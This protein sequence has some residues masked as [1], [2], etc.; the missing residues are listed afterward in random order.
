MY[1]HLWT[2]ESRAWV[3]ENYGNMLTRELA[4]R[5]SQQTGHRF[6][7]NMVVGLAWRH[8]LV[9]GKRPRKTDTTA[10]PDTGMLTDDDFTG[11][12]HI[13][14]APL[15]LRHGMYCCQ[16]TVNGSDYCE[17]HNA[18]YRIAGSATVPYV[19]RAARL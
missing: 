12:R 6:T 7:K 13:T 18:R 3:I 16:P 10:Q 4:A 17:A 8:G 9:T 1:G 19:G 5:L 2:D 14:G 15:P 11:C